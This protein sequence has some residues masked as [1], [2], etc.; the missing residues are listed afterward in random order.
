MGERNSVTREDALKRL[1]TQILAGEGPDV[2]ILDNMPI[3]SYIEK[4]LLADLSPLLNEMSGENGIFENVKNAFMT[5]GHIYTVP[6]ELQ[7]PFILGRG[8]DT[9]QMKDLEGIADTVENMRR[10]NPGKNLLEIASAK[11]IMR[12][13]SLISA[14]AWRTESGEIDSEAISD[15]LIQTKRI[16]DAQMDGLPERAIEDWQELSDYY[17]E[18]FGKPIED[19]VYIRTYAGELQFMGDVRKCAMGSLSSWYGYSRAISAWTTDGFEDCEI[20]PMNGQCENVFWA[21]T[22][23]G[24]NAVSENAGMAEDFLRTALDK[25]NQMGLPGGM[26]VTREGLLAD[27]EGSKSRSQ[28]G[29]FGSVAAS[30]AEGTC[31]SLTI[32]FPED[33]EVEFLVNWIESADT[34]Y[35]EDAAF[36]EAVYEEGVAYIN[37]EKSLESAVDGIEKKLAIYLAE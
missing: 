25:E 36:E 5:D 14:P 6:C 27:L 17:V 28:S 1:N 30:N 26:P 29:I 24:I 13:F 8:K 19:T 16:Y 9:A 32:R 23:L 33:D 34:V 20:I 31:V 10:S 15:F 37:E 3:D 7:L 2:L 12:M 35:I 4:G 21:R 18:D 22:M 11:G